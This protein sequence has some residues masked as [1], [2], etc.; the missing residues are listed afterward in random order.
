MLHL[1]LVTDSDDLR[2]RL[3]RFAPEVEWIPAGS[4]DEAVELLARSSRVDAVVVAREFLDLGEDRL[5]ENAALVPDRRRLRIDQGLAVAAAIRREIPGNL[6]LAIL[7]VDSDEIPESLAALAWPA[8]TV[9][10]EAIDG[11][12]ERLVS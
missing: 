11:L 3:T 12:L 8:E 4:G 7:G 5:L 9:T 1:L 2:R 10:G 6:P